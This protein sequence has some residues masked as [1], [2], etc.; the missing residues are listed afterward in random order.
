MQ[1]L[2]NNISNILNVSSSTTTNFSSIFVHFPQLWPF[3]CLLIVIITHVE[4]GCDCFKISETRSLRCS[5]PLRP[6]IS[7]SWSD[8][9]STFTN[10]SSSNCEQAR[11]YHN[12]SQE[13]FLIKSL[14]LME[15]L[16]SWSRRWNFY[17]VTFSEWLNKQDHSGLRT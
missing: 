1:P 16:F 2:L 13:P 15:S 5:G 8:L 10:C 6:V 12:S 17:L 9:N 14:L 4:L 7:S 11:C 3:L